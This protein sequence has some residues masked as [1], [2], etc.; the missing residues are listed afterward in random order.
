MVDRRSWLLGASSLVAGA[1][2]GRTALGSTARALSLERLLR[3]TEH[4]AVARATS[5][6]CRW[7]TIGGQRRIVTYS[8]LE[9][10]E[11]VDGAP[12]RELWL[13]TLG[14]QVDGVGQSV[15]GEAILALG[16][17]GWVFAGLAPDAV[18]A[19]AGLAQG[20]YPVVADRDRVD[21]LGPSPGLPALRELSETSALRRLVGARP[22]EAAD[23]VKRVR[24]ETR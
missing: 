7:E 22:S 4:V 8:R 20:H 21:R 14:G 10:L 17:V 12:G 6:E 13:R 19:V 9:V 2:L 1:L 16:E 24:R 11:A 15:A 23:L 5:A 3:L 18:P